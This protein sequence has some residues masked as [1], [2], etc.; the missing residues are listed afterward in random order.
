[1]TTLKKVTSG[2]YNFTARYQI[3]E[4]CNGIEISFS[5]KPGDIIRDKLK[6]A[7][8]RWHSVKK[9]WYAKRSESREEL[10]ERLATRKKRMDEE[11][12]AAHSV[13]LHK[14]DTVKENAKELPELLVVPEPEFVDGGGLYDGW[15]GGNN[16][17]WRDEKEL[18]NL[19]ISDLKRAGIS[20]TI[21][22]SR[23]GY[24]TSLTVT[25]KINQSDIKSFDKWE[26]DFRAPG[27]GWI[28]YY[29]EAGKIND[30]FSEKYWSLSREDRA[31]IDPFIKKTAYN[32]AVE[33]FDKSVLSEEANKKYK[34]A[35]AIVSSYNKDCSNGQIDYFDR[36]IY[37]Y[38]TF[39]VV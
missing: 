8:F 18:K 11:N 19:L 20:A 13:A 21:R 15:K 39:K 6:K 25:I 23:G 10:A 24:L 9:V 12:V 14:L 3:N 34:T 4:E 27:S 31:K 30:I 29:D 7:G 22:F 37:D 17:K 16:H 38:Y 2:C 36:D 1:M 28:S 26:K 33:R 32:N 5:E 35:V